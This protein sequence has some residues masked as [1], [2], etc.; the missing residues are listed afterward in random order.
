MDISSED[1][2]YRKGILEYLHEIPLSYFY[3]DISKQY[4]DNLY[5]D[6]TFNIFFHKK[7]PEIIKCN[8]DYYSLYNSK[9]NNNNNNFFLDFINKIKY[10]YTENNI[11]YLN[12]EFIRIVTI[13]KISKYDDILKDCYYGFYYINQL[14]YFIPNFSYTYYYIER[15]SI[16]IKNNIVKSWGS[17]TNENLFPYIIK[18]NPKN[19]IKLSDFLKTNNND[20]NINIILIQYYNIINL[21]NCIFLNFIMNDLNLNNYYIKKLDYKIEIPIYNN[22]YIKIT[23]S[24]ETNIILY[25]T[26]YSNFII[27]NINNK[28][29]NIASNNF[30]N[31][32][33]KELGYDVNKKLNIKIIKPKKIYSYHH[34]ISLNN[35]L[36]YS[37]KFLYKKIIL[38]CNDNNI[39]ILNNDEDSNN[40]LD[41]NENIDYLDDIDNNF[42][43]LY[44]NSNKDIRDYMEIFFENRIDKILNNDNNDIN[45]NYEYRKYKYI[46]NKYITKYI[47]NIYINLNITLPQNSYDKF[48]KLL[49]FLIDKVKC[50]NYSNKMYK[51]YTLKNNIIKYF[52]NNNYLNKDILINN[53][54]FK[55]ENLTNYNK[56]KIFLSKYNNI[57]IILKLYA[58]YYIYLSFLFYYNVIT[59]TIK[60]IENVPLE[61]IP[62]GS[63]MSFDIITNIPLYSNNYLLNSKTIKLNIK[64]KSGL[65]DLVNPIENKIIDQ[66]TIYRYNFS[67]QE[68][69]I[70]KF[71]RSIYLFYNLFINN[72]KNFEY[73]FN[74]N[75]FLAIEKT[76]QYI[77][78][79]I[80]KKNI[81]YNL[82]LNNIFSI[83]EIFPIIF[84]YIAKHIYKMIL[85]VNT[86]MIKG[87]SINDIS[88]YINKN[89]NILINNNIIKKILYDNISNNV[90]YLINKLWLIYIEEQNINFDDILNKLKHDSYPENYEMI[91]FVFYTINNITSI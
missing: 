40:I 48:C 84:P 33:S 66:K 58:Y 30:I 24:L 41:N 16:E 11:I 86:L 14:K 87:G 78:K 32:I 56:I 85:Y 70:K 2:F 55:Y 52:Y 27:N 45:K 36:D 69:K 43:I 63:N 77:I 91:K 15:K 39:E 38:H 25:I 61:K 75:K 22:Q 10:I 88:N 50:I 49:D 17:I 82:F 64:V 34:F 9:N 46:L 20:E 37:I 83:E 29:L 90:E 5:K 60:I 26:N 72:N 80:D 79:S 13:D 67:K 62:I 76:I 89:V 35:S 1:N 54:N 12:D 71:I 21:T 7:I 42:N 47:D 53:I 28:Y 65:I 44:K 31:L 8:E 81:F 59:A 23:G 73:Q 57:E 4:L 19:L 74:N 6:N 51:L 18:E 68:I 3:I